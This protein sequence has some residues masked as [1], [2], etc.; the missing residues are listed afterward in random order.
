LLPVAYWVDG[1]TGLKQT[2]KMAW[3]KKTIQPEELAAI[4]PIPE[5]V[6][7]DNDFDVWA[8]VRP[9]LVEA[10][11]AAVDEAI[12]FGVNAPTSFPP[13]L[14]EAAVAANN[15]YEMGTNAQGVGGLAEDINQ[16]MA[17]VEDEGFDVNGFVT[18][19]GF[20]ARLRGARDTTGQKLLDVTTNTIEGA[21]VRYAMSGLWPDDGTAE[22]FAGDFSQGILGI[23]QDITY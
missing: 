5:N 18:H 17:L 9:R 8:E 19:R 3:D 21:P 12:F 20:R 23:R 13:S 4:V 2:T 16:L 11:G 15:D 22:L 1:D 7:D 14:V 6:L 10:I